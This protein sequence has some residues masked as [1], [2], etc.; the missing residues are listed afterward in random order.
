M[1]PSW[2]AIG[3]RRNACSTPVHYGKSESYGRKCM[4]PVGV[5]PSTAR[6]PN[7]PPTNL[8]TCW[9]RQLCTTGSQPS[10]CVYIVHYID[11]IYL[12]VQR[13]PEVQQ[14][15][16]YRDPCRPRSP[17]HSSRAAGASAERLPVCA[18]CSMV[19]DV[20]GGNAVHLLVG[21]V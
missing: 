2:A 1:S 15:V 16:S 13:Y 14:K 4:Q 9:S 6:L 11:T 5:E 10:F 3:S 18:Q 12:I 20:F 8:R 21:P 17:S 19:A 7:Q